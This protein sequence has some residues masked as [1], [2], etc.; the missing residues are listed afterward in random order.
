MKRL[1]RAAGAFV[2]GALAMTTLSC[3]TTR[4]KTESYLFGEPAR[5]AA[6]IDAWLRT[7]E[8]VSNSLPLTE[9]YALISDSLVATASKHGFQLSVTRGSQPYVV[10]LV[11]HEHSSVVDL[12]TRNSVLVVLNIGELNGSATPVARVVHSVVM[13]DSIVS[14]HQVAEIGEK[15]FA[16]LRASVEDRLKK[17][18]DDAKAKPGAGPTA[19]APAPAEQAPAQAAA[20]APAEQAPTP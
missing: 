10:D 8:V 1:L 5:L 12:A 9:D 18:R 7:V 20:P 6:P 16:S 13:P 14:L 4:E 17:E 3:A 19:A 11:M 15:V 2:L